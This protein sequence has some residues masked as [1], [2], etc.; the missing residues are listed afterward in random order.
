MRGS[1]PS[2]NPSQAIIG[3]K[4]R[5]IEKNGIFYGALLFFA[6]CLVFVD[7]QKVKFIEGAFAPG[8]GCL[9]EGRDCSP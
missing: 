5:I 7:F 2:V 6:D 1:P 9:E 3:Q 8:I 4:I